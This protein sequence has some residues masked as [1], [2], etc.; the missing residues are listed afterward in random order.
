MPYRHTGSE[1]SQICSYSSRDEELTHSHKEE[2]QKEDWL[3]DESLHSSPSFPVSA[4]LYWASLSEI[5][6]PTS[7]KCS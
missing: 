5:Q 2:E 7:A 6:T 1:A 3:A 4:G